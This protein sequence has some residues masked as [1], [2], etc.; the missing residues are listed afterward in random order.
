MIAADLPFSR[1]Q[2]F[3]LFERYNETVWPIQIGLVV[4]A[5]LA[6][7]RTWLS[8]DE[9]SPR[10][11]VAWVLALLWT[12]MAIGYHFIFFSRI[13]PAA[14]AFGAL[15]LAGAIV[16][17]RHATASSNAAVHRAN[18]TDIRL[19][20]MLGF[21]LI[22]YAL[23]GYPLVNRYVG[24]EVYPRTPTFGLPCPTTIFTL[25]ALLV[26]KRSFSVTGFIV[27]LVWS[28]IGSFAAFQ[29]GVIADYGLLVAGLATAAVLVHRVHF[30]SLRAK[31]FRAR[32]ARHA[33]KPE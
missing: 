4:L 32:G 6:I 11:A 2:F 27:P 14:W 7:V 9:R 12:W 29:L 18:P 19:E 30:A 1:E 25:G 5:V 8:S 22:L 33:N 23:I 24:H 10:S 26:V 15:F 16:F 3:S 20:H 17:A 28:V 31:W 21:V 13:N